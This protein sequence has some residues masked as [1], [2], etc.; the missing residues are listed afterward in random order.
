MT[1]MTLLILLMRVQGSSKLHIYSVH[2][3]IRQSSS[4][5]VKHGADCIFL[6]FRIDPKLKPTYN[7]DV[8][9][10]FNVEI[11]LKYT[12]AEYTKK[13]IKNPEG[14]EDLTMIAKFGITFHKLAPKCGS[15]LQLI[16][17]V[18]NNKK[19]IL[20]RIHSI[21]V[22]ILEKISDQDLA[23]GD[24]SKIIKDLMSKNRRLKRKIKEL[25]EKYQAL[26]KAHNCL[27]HM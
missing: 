17:G 15:R 23:K 25:D 12:E 10:D 6:K 16:A 14:G 26:K 13:S 18:Y 21:P 3:L 1:A 19:D 4:K 9:G 20:P 7:K 24:E 27:L 5:C 8:D 11:F 2:S 22:Q